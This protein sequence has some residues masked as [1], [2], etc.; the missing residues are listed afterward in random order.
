M[1]ED[2]VWLCGNTK[3]TPTGVGFRCT[4]KAASQLPKLRTDVTLT[5]AEYLPVPAEKRL[6]FTE[7]ISLHNG[8]MKVY[9]GDSKEGKQTPC[10]L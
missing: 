2:I 6:E 3:V 10:P 1:T 9:I 5:H 4:K 7:I 8:Y